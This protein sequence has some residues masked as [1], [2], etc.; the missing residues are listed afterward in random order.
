MSREREHTA[1]GFLSGGFQAVAILAGSDRGKYGNSQIAG[2][3]LRLHSLSKF[4][5]RGSLWT[6][7][8][9]ITF[10]TCQALLKTQKSRL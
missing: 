10:R 7:D 3:F 6:P 2:T 5:L 4:G 8:L 1:L 9:A